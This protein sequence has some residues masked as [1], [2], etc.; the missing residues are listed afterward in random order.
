MF[1]HRDDHCS[2]YTHAEVNFK[3]NSTR[4]GMCLQ[5]ACLSCQAALTDSTDTP[6]AVVL[7]ATL[8]TLKGCCSLHEFSQSVAATAYTLQ[9]PSSHNMTQHD[10]IPSSP[11]SESLS[12]CSARAARDSRASAPWASSG[13]P[14]SITL[15]RRAVLPGLRSSLTKSSPNS[16]VC[17]LLRL[18][19]T[20]SISAVS[21][22]QWGW[23]RDT[24]SR[25]EDVNKP[26]LCFCMP[27][28]TG[29][30]HFLGR[31]RDRN[32]CRITSAPHRAVH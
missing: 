14:G 28:D 9:Q 4:Y 26:G 3:F 16:L 10:T 24:S 25:L 12:A 15:R 32:R 17:T 5:A 8:H 13:P 2:R 11:D 20:G 29:R 1:Y 22:G 23:S 7:Q 19:P 6:T 30:P 21:Q 31:G 27:R 18:C